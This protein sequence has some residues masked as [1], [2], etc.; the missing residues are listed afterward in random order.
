M[1]AVFYIGRT[2]TG[3]TYTIREEIKDT[4]LQAPADGKAVIYLVPDQMT[5]QAEYDLLE[6]TQSGMTRGHVLSFSRMAW[7]V[8][9]ETGGI[10][11]TYLQQTGMQMVVRKVVEEQKNRLRLYKQAVDKNGFIEQ[12]EQL[13]TEFKQQVISIEALEQ[14][15]T[16]ISTQET[17]APQGQV[18][19]D[20]LHDIVH[21]WKGV[22]ELLGDRYAGTEDYL[23][24]L[25]E[26]V[27]LSSFLEGAEIYVDGFHSFTPQELHVIGELLKHAKHMTFALTLDR[28]Y[29]EEP[30]H[31]L[32]LFQQTGTSYQKLHALCEAAG[33][34][35]TET[36]LF[37][38]SK[39]Y[40]SQNL[41][42]L[43]QHFEKRPVKT[44]DPDNSI[45]ISAAVNKR[46]EVESV[47]REV[48][49]LVESNSCRYK[50]IAILGRNIEDYT[51]MLETI[52]ADYDIPLFNDQ[53]R[54]MLN[55]PVIE[56]IRSCLET[57][58][59][60]WRYEPLFRA[61]KTDMFFSI[62]EDW[63][64]AREQID[65]LENYVLAYGIK[66]KHW[67]QSQPWTYSKRTVA[68]K[69]EVQ[70][71]KE[72]AF[73]R[74]IQTL[75][76][77]YSSALLQFEKR[78]KKKKTIKE[79]AAELF[80]FLEE[81]YIPQKIEKLRNKAVEIGDIEKARE[82]EQV[83]GAVVDLLEQVVEMA[84]DD[85]VSLSSFYKIVETGLESM[86]F[87]IVPPAIDQVTAADMERS[88][89]ANIKMVFVIGANEGTLPASLDED[90]M[91]DDEER[92]WFQKQG[93][94][95]AEDSSQKLLNEQFLIY[96]VFSLAEEKLWVSYPL[97]DEEGKSLQPSVVI[98]QLKETFPDLEEKL[99]FND[100][101]EYTAS[102]Q[103]H[104]I[105]AH[106][107]TLSFLT[108][109]LQH[110][111]KGYPISSVW[112]DVYNH[113]VQQDRSAAIPSVLESLFYTNQP[114][115]LS[116]K[117]SKALYGRTLK[118]S[119]SRVEQY[120]ACAFAQFASYGLRLKEREVYKLEAPDIGQLFHAALKEMT[121]IIRKNHKDWSGLSAEECR[122][123]AKQS[124]Q[125]LGPRIQR[126]ILLSSDR[127]K[128]L[129]KKLE[130]TVAKAS[131]ILRQ[132]AAVSGFSPYGVEVGFGPNE[133][134]PPLRFSLPQGVDMEVAGRIDRVDTASGS[135]GVYVRIIDYKSSSKDIHLSDVYY[136]LALQMLVYLDVVLSFSQEWLDKQAAPAGMLYFH[137][138]NPFIQA[139]AHLSDTDIEQELLKR[140]K[141]KGL[142]LADEQAVRLM[143][144]NLTS[145][146]SQ[147]VPAAI[148]KDGTFYNSS[149]VL[150]TDHFQ[151]LRKFIRRKLQD[152]GQRIIQGQTDIYPYKSQQ[153]TAC[154]FCA[155]KPVCQFDT[156]F[157][158]NDYRLL[159]E[160]K[161]KMETQ[162]F[163]KEAEK[164][165]SE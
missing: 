96:R 53:K 51:E 89:L 27:E 82:H 77:T 78:M 138:H 149:S 44:A 141:M 57:I 2:G 65:E 133:E 75:R 66:E 123:L 1:G 161:E 50:D 143:D 163:A 165:Q 20:K 127:Y 5:F 117:T 30:P 116:A 105:G 92:H 41:M 85:E 42:H 17:A 40:A 25:A 150:Q 144:Q 110:W 13:L 99:L 6:R 4:L 152:I 115:K 160:S 73:E 48:R 14:K 71:E 153:M 121:E 23:R 104:F 126:E 12:M 33:C 111:K 90:G 164:E 120:E 122:K 61:L 46:T 124:V 94:E 159:S 69:T 147:V 155:F 162:M 62:E 132:Q 151:A 79:Y 76:D 80:Q 118:A 7:R 139:K 67:K 52:F 11:K 154:T 54:P 34:E 9:K 21:I 18:F 142:L 157:A 129:Q 125:S 119:V 36:I 130:D 29:D 59:E 38:D 83:W 15:Y 74:R 140:F 84:G 8:L 56:C 95:L 81:L 32:D 19:I 108:S 60:H 70:G 86:N 135:D 148:K 114:V 47:A 28:P 24:L 39:K 31:M 35:S 101:H 22:E 146:H 103:M 109:Q 145:G 16:E 98:Q 100:P 26:K 113:Y 158:A 102:G 93:L 58:T 156:S 88:R 68:D 107:K 112:W 72:K 63:E 97:A 49:R 87:R 128:Y 45:S 43:E 37:R 106:R 131:D 64:E 55:H 137:V 10:T 136:G 91:I 134:L 3:K